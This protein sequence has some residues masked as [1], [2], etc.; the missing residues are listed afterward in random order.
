MSL[1]MELCSYCQGRKVAE[2]FEE[3]VGGTWRPVPGRCY[4]GMPAYAVR[5]LQQTCVDRHPDAFRWSEC[6]CPQ[7]DGHGEYEV[8]YVTCKVF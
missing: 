8:E 3:R 7:C 4:D 2:R 1:R 6:A 5:E